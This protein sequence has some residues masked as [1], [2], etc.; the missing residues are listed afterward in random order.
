M[1][2]GW[3]AREVCMGMAPQEHTSPPPACLT[4]TAPLPLR[5]CPPRNKAEVV[6]E[7]SPNVRAS[8]TIIYAERLEEVLLAAF[9][10]PYHLLPRPRM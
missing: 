1:H 4:P 2:D 6:S 7:V 8:L 5:P 3:A 9:D 10:P